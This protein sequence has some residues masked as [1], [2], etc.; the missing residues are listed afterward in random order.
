[1]YGSNIQ[2]FSCEFFRIFVRLV[3]HETY[4]LQNRGNFVNPIIEDG[5]TTYGSNAREE[6]SCELFAK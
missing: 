6:V 2:D 1:M 5:L 3:K 4:I